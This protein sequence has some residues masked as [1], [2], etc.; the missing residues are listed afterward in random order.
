MPVAAPSPG[1]I[2]HASPECQTYRS[3]ALWPQ[4]LLWLPRRRSPQTSAC[5]RSLCAPPTERHGWHGVSPELKETYNG[6]RQK[7]PEESTATRNHAPGTNRLA[8]FGARGKEVLEPH[9]RGMGTRGRR[10]SDPAARSAPGHRRPRRPSRTETR[11]GG[12]LTALFLIG[13]AEA[14]NRASA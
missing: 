14:R 5:A 13:I 12:G 2:P 1:L 4:A 11:G 10:G 7:Q 3:A 9:R 6:I 8:R